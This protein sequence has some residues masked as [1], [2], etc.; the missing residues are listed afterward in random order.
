MILSREQILSQGF[1]EIRVKVAGIQQRHKFVIVKEKTAFGEVPYLETKGNV[2]V[3]E[4]ARLAQEFDLPV[5][6][7]LGKVFPPGK[8]P[9]DFATVPPQNP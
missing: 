4:L 1:A 3:S 8:G 2:T 7:P 9:K 6:S 5:R